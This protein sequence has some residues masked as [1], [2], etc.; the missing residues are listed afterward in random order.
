MKKKILIALD[1]DPTAQ[2]VAEAGY[3]LAKAMNADITLLHVVADASYYSSIQ[4]SPIMGYNSFSELDMLQPNISEQLK[5]G[6]L[7]FLDNSRKHLGDETIQTMVTEG[8]FATAILDAAVDLH[9]DV[10]VMGTHSRRG[11]D[12]ILMGSVAEKVLRHTSIPIFIVPTRE[13]KE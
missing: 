13:E 3:V 2:K 10:I 1:Y 11:L 6:A 5:E 12:K 7:Q 8:D 9:A 4:Y